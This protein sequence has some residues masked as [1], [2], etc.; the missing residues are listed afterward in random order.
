MHVLLPRL[1]P[2]PLVMLL[3]QAAGCLL[4]LQLQQAGPLLLVGLPVLQLGSWVQLV[5]G[6]QHLLSDQQRLL[7]LLSFQ[8]NRVNHDIHADLLLLLLVLGGA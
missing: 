6:P 2:L 1:W 7:L 3:P 4:W 5:R 8:L